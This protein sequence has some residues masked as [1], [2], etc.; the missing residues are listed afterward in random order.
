MLLGYAN[1]GII[2]KL[3]KD[4]IMTIFK[5]TIK[6]LNFT[7]SL[8]ALI[9]DRLIVPQGVKKVKTYNIAEVKEHSYFSSDLFLDNKFLLL[10]PEL[11]VSETLKNLLAKWDFSTVC[12]EGENINVPE[13]GNLESAAGTV[14]KT[15]EKEKLSES[16]KRQNELLDKVETKYK[17]FLGAVFEFHETAKQG[18][19]LNIRAV[20]DLAKDLVEFI[21][22]RN[23]QILLIDTQQFADEYDYVILHEI[24]ST[25]FAVV[26]GRYLKLPTYKLIELATACLIHE[27]GMARVPPRVYNSTKPLTVQE[28][29]VL[30]A[31]PILSYNIVNASSFALPICLACLEHH[32]RDNGGGYPRR[33]S[34]NRLSLYGKIIAVACSYEAITNP[35]PY[36]YAKS[37]TT[38][39]MELVK[40]ENKQYDDNVLKAL[41]YS[42]SFFPIGTYVILSDGRYAQVVD[43]NPDDPR[44][45]IVQILG[46]MSSGG[47]LKVV[48]TDK[49][50]LYIARTVNKT[51]IDPALLKRN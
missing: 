39:I 45:P 8:W 50:T 10:I 4:I 33:L 15:A 17:E 51:D 3:I 32:E 21:E 31:H 29:Q 18:L 23:K 11:Q 44:F 43:V 35:R 30:L 49:D 6:N 42:V 25:V 27:I 7:K 37:P 5:V 16:T 40:N 22:E 12:S 26:I 19:N 34:A 36:R 47:N 13:T 9:F 46:E 24:G 38:A 20:S 48:G 2:K 28:K 14:A 1:K 41:L